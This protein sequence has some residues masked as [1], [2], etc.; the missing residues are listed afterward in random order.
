VWEEARHPWISLPPDTPP[1][2]AAKQA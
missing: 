2:R 1:K